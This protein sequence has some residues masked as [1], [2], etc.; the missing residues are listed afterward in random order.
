MKKSRVNPGAVIECLRSARLPGGRGFEGVEMEECIS[1]LESAHQF[2]PDTVPSARPEIVSR[3][4]F[5]VSRKG[6]LSWGRIQ[7]E[8]RRQEE[9]EFKQSRKRYVLVTEISTDDRDVLGKHR[10]GDGLVKIRRRLPRRYD[11]SS[12]VDSLA[13][14]GLHVSLRGY[15]WLT[16]H[17]SARH[18]KEAFRAATRSLDLMRAFWNY[19]VN[20]RVGYRRSFGGMVRPVNV[21]RLGQ[22]HT[23][24]ESTG[25]AVRSGKYWCEQYISTAAASGLP[26]RRIVSQSRKLRR[27]MGSVL[28]RDVL[29]D[30]F[31]AYCRSL[32]ETDFSV[33]FMKLWSILEHLTGTV[34][35]RYDQLIRRA[36]FLYGDPEYP[37]ASLEDLR[38]RRNRL[39]HH[40]SEWGAD[41]GL[42]YRLK[43]FVEHLLS[44]H[45]WMGGRFQSHEEACR[46]LDYSPDTGHLQR[47]MILIR[48]ALRFSGG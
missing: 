25:A 3:A 47:Q 13:N 40:S 46:F 23:L 5:A 24:H 34:G 8:I 43:G 2:D 36:C 1:I 42:V 18:S 39:V 12:I 44:F 35:S 16:V 45:V 22:V 6:V 7:E 21:L 15:S 20:R 37:R 19:D 38:E 26:W 32:D 4:V 27:R 30:L 31:V 28:Y 17:V 9:Q 48:E 33:S 29:E 14:N 10:I 11:R 41:E